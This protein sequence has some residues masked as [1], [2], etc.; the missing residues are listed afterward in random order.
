MSAGSYNIY[1][2]Q[3]AT[4]SQTFTWK[5]NKNAVDLTSYS[6]RMKFK[7]TKRSLEIITLTSASG[8]ITLNSSGQIAVTMSATVTDNLVDGIYLYDLELQSPG[9][10][11]T[12]LLQGEVTVSPNITR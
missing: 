6:A 2:E 4:Y 10:V 12:R 9:G 11:V 8:A 3:G 5:I 1:I 7:H